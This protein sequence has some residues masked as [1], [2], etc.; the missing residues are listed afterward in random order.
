MF[1]VKSFWAKRLIVVVSICS[2]LSGCSINQLAVNQMGDALA[3]GGTTFSSDDD[4]E[5]IREALPFSL[6]LMESLLV[7]SPD[8]AGLLFATASGFTQYGYAFV[9]QD[10][11][12]LEDTD[13]EASEVSKERAKR[14]Y[15]RA[16]SY[17]LRG[18]SV[19]HPDFETSLRRNPLEA[20]AST[21]IDDVPLLYWTA[22]SWLA[23][24]GLS[25]D[26]PEL[27]GDLTI[28]EALIDRALAL[29]EGYDSGAIHSFL[30]TYEMIRQSGAGDPADRARAH[31]SRAIELSEGRMVSPYLALA[32]AVSHSENNLKEFTD[33]LEKALA[34]NPDDRPEWRLSNLIY[35]KRARWLL[36]RTDLLFLD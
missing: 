23:A 3:K 7:E 10:A 34:I 5:L 20:V 35:Q 33:L 16:R 32:E 28:V 29:D 21:E 26:D 31:F 11:E 6:K 17:G 9:Q 36:G 14:L 27:V 25:V 19:H 8:H 15:L 2:L 13:F 1:P 30:I 22:V 4:P 12:V 18:L 24:I